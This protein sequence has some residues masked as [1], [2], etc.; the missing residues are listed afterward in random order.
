MTLSLFPMTV[1]TSN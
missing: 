1:R